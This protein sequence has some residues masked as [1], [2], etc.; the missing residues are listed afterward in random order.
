VSGLDPA[1]GLQRAGETGP[2]AAA[3][4]SATHGQSRPNPT[5]LTAH[6]VGATRLTGVARWRV[7]RGLTGGSLA[8]GSRAMGGVHRARWETAR[9]TEEVGR[10]WG[11]GERPARRCSN[12]GGRLD[13][14]WRSSALPYDSASGR[15][16]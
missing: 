9:L 4:R 6:S 14:S 8:A 1:H 16:R 13:G 3:R 5:V 15:K 10:R 11:G 2:H 7:G 12:G